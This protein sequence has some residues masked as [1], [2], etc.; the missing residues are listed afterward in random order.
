MAKVVFIEPGGSRR[1]TAA[2]VGMTLMEIAR[3]NG[4]EGIV[5]RCGGACACATCHVYVAPE[6]LA[7]VEPREDMEEGMLESAWEPRDNSRLSCQ[8]HITPELDGLTVQLP[9][10]QALAEDDQ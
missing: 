1:E 9:E 10:R 4:I 3:Q 5:A 7:R 6:W 8:I 2:P